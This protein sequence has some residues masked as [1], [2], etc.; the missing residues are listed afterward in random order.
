MANKPIKIK[1]NNSISGKR[2]QRNS[3]IK[4]VLSLVFALGALL[5]IGF[6]GA[7]AVMEMVDNMSKPKPQNTPSPTPVVTAPAE[8]QPTTNPSDVQDDNTKQKFVYGALEQNALYNED[9][10]KN[11]VAALKAKGVDNVVV[12]LKDPQGLVWF[13]TQTEMGTQAKSATVADV[14]R[15]VEICADNDVEFT[16]Q[17]YVFHDRIAPTVNRDTAVKYK[18][19]DM[20]WLDSSK[21]LGGKPWANPASSV[22]QQYIYDLAK[23]LSDMGVKNFIFSGVQLPTGYSLEMRDFGV[24][25]AQLQAQLQGFINTLT[26]KVDAWGGD[27]YFAFDV[28]AISGADVAKYIITPQRYGPANIVVTGTAENFAAYGEG[29]HTALANDENVERIV[30]WNTDGNAETDPQAPN[31]YFV[32]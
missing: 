14:K 2:R 7:P 13:D 26:S 15:L 20:N 1:R 31:G 22:M 6:L 12:T 10:F 28:V 16:A 17:L 8:S 32:K 24:S 19:T 18:D 30:V 5:A 3:V 21:E 29:A 4:K 9:T 11:A 23:E 27:A 25:D